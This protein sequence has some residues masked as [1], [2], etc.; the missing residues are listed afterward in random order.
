[1]QRRIFW[2]ILL[3]GI[4]LGGGWFFFWRGTI[5]FV[6]PV[7]RFEIVFDTG[8]TVLCKSVPC[9]L[10]LRAGK[11][12]QGNVLAEGFL[13]SS[14]NI[15]KVSAFHT[16]VFSL[17]LIQKPR[18]EK[19]SLPAFEQLRTEKEI[20]FD[21]Q[22]SEIFGPVLFDS[23]GKFAVFAK[24]ESEGIVLIV[25]DTLGRQKTLT[26]ITGNFNL[27]DMYRNFRMQTEGII[28]PE[29]KSVFFFDFALRRKQKIWEGNV[30]RLEQ[31]SV[32]K[33]KSFVAKELDRWV[34]FDGKDFQSLPKDTLT[35]S[36]LEGFLWRFSEKGDIFLKNEKIHHIPENL[37]SFYQFWFEKNAFFLK[38]D[39]EVWKIIF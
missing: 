18:R 20:P 25:V 32:G 39:E 9:S 27:L 26:A 10:R 28:I 8:K 22:K 30:Q 21:I 34:L 23:E 36:F 24:Q 33:E 31:I 12:F 14:F 37:A 3:G 15:D 35:A 19:F 16:K 2:I 4:F 13:P 17:S 29:E 7:Q 1:M 5:E 11:E 38:G 6:L